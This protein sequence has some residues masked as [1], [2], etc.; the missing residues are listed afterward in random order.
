MA[1]IRELIRLKGLKVATRVRSS[2]GESLQFKGM[3]QSYTGEGLVNLALEQSEYVKAGIRPEDAPANMQTSAL[4]AP[5]DA[6]DAA[7]LLCDMPG[8]LPSERIEAERKAKEDAETARKAK[9]DAER[10]QRE[11]KEQEETTNEP[12]VTNGRKG[13]GK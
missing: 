1:S 3:P 2:E 11:A 13:R 12:T 8:V 9:E 7:A 5:V 6:A 4:L 10:A